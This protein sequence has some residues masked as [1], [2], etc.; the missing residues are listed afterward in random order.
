MSADEV[1]TSQVVGLAD[2]SDA[3]LTSLKP[4]APEPTGSVVVFDRVRH[5]SGCDR[6]VAR[7]VQALN[8]TRERGSAG[9]DL[10]GKPAVETARDQPFHAIAAP[11]QPAAL[12]GEVASILQECRGLARVGREDGVV[13]DRARPGGRIGKSVGVKL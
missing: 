7:M 9:F 11:E 4:H 8:S 13:A 6:G 3:T 2:W 1:Q 12:V 10:R 5:R